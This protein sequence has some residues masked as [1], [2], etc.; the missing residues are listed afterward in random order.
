MSP[1]NDIWAVVP[2]KE[3]AGAKQRLAGFMTP[4]QRRTLAATMVE[5]VL[6][7]LASVSRLAGIVVVTSDS[8]AV[9]LAGR[10]GARVMAEGS[11]AGQTAA[12]G[13]AARALAGEGRA[14]M[15]TVPG[16]IP[17]ITADEVAAVLDAH[18]QQS[19]LTPGFTP[20][21]TIVPAHDSRGS[22]AILCAPPDA[23]PL[24]FGNDSFRP[25]LAAARRLRIEP[26]VVRLPG[27]GL[28]IDHPADLGRFLRFSPHRRG[29]TLALVEETG[30]AE[31]LTADEYR[32]PT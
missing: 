8:M 20:A 23:V 1:A 13:A 7:V 10:I 2:V 3:F 17:L 27:I 11:R 9:V 29:R 22:N 19:A 30:L 25:H 18:D 6:E 5:D 16:D 15:L 31:R 12:V 32:E 21:F 24:Q 14:G 26:A 28:D 4:G